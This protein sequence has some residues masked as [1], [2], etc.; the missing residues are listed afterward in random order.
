MG[1]FHPECVIRCRC[2]G[3]HL[4]QRLVRRACRAHARFHEEETYGMNAPS[5]PTSNI[6]LKLAP[7]A[8]TPS[9]TVILEQPSPAS[10]ARV[11]TV[12]V[13]AQGPGPGPSR[14]PIV[15][16]VI[17]FWL[18]M[19][20]VY[21]G[22]LTF[23]SAR[24]I[25]GAVQLETWLRS[26][27]PSQESQAR[28]SESPAEPEATEAATT[29]PV[30]GIWSTI[31]LAAKYL[32]SELLQRWPFLLVAAV[33]ITLAGLC[34]GGSLMGFWVY[35]ILYTTVGV[36]AAA[37]IATRLA[38]WLGFEPSSL[39]II[40]LMAAVA[41]VVHTL[42]DGTAPKTSAVLGLMCTCLAGLGVLRG[43][44]DNP[45]WVAKVS[46]SSAGFVSAWRGE[47][48][49]GVVLVLTV[50][51]VL[52]S[53][54]RS[55][56]FLNALLL[57][58]L[59]YACIREGSIKVFPFEGTNWKPLEMRDIAYMPTWRWVLVGEL[60]LLACVLLH[61]AR[62]VG[63]IAMVMA[64]AWL[65]FVLHVDRDMG[66]GV[67][68]TYSKAAEIATARPVNNGTAIGGD[69]AVRQTPSEMFS[70]FPT[71]PT[72]EPRPQYS[73]AQKKALLNKATTRVAIYYIWIYLTAIFAGVIG[74]AGLRMM[75]ANPKARI[76]T[77]VVIW[78]VFGATAVWLWGLWPSSDSW[79]AAL[80]ALVVPKTHVYAIIISA[81]GSLAVFASWS[82][83]HD[84]RYT[85]W[86]YVAAAITFIG[87]ILTLVGI[88]L[89]IK[90]TGLDPFKVWVYI[91]LTIA[92][93]L[94]MWV[95]F[96]HQS[97]RARRGLAAD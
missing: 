19:L 80:T 57:A 95:L 15:I 94:L 18:L 10:S 26:A 61:M 34:C 83:Q 8:S 6:E 44:Y 28:S 21:V 51:G 65:A 75:I 52:S 59:A 97:D 64:C 5:Q 2:V 85:A 53:R 76:F 7:P 9:R 66:R 77:L 63:S 3:I 42:G 45:E 14:R 29:Q 32:W 93:S 47:V 81:I 96:V 33:L 89:L 30:T 54:G 31:V 12:R 88:V 67:I 82:L 17:G 39:S 36:I 25:P 90:L 70:F 16:R 35:S 78:F 22:S 43:W 87:T 86:V 56:H 41:F 84:S 62:G 68:L 49:W 1:Q 4:D 11:A 72:N 20:A 92:Q 55:I 40:M 79:V 50:I 13:H 27:L 69:G 74:A 91:A 58:A 60:V 71:R 38:G 37:L 24:Q 46:E 48:V 23:E 73:D